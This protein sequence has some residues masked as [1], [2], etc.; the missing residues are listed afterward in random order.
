MEN[1]LKMLTKRRSQTFY[2]SA[3]ICSVATVV[4]KSIPSVPMR[5]IMN[6]LNTHDVWLMVNNLKNGKQF[7]DQMKR[8]QLSLSFC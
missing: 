5:N 4:G 7:S 8:K 6:Q 2:K 1:L 3:D